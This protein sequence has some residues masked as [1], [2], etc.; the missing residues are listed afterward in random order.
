VI[1]DIKDKKIMGG[2]FLKIENPNE[3]SKIAN[4]VRK[5]NN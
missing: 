3:L 1:L 5:R 4:N 2:I